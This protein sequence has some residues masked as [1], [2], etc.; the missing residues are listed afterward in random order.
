MSDPLDAEAERQALSALV[1]SDGWRLLVGYANTT[2]SA[3]AMLGQIAAWAGRPLLGQEDAQREAASIVLAKFEAVQEFMQLPA[4]R[5]AQIDAA[6][7]RA[8]QAQET[9]VPSRGGYR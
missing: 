5:I 9:G 2:F 6:E 1:A 8:V 4:K 3:R 7:A